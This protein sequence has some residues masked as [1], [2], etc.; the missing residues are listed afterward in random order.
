MGNF[1][2]RELIEARVREFHTLKQDLLSF[3]VYRIKFTKL[4]LYVKQIA[5][6]I[7]SR[8]SFFVAGISHLLSKKGMATMFISEIYTSRFMVYL[9]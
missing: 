3:H 4:S 5:M 9:Q 2:S 7:R 6:D 8:M 1:F